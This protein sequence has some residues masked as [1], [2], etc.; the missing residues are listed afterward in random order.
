MLQFFYYIFIFDTLQ[1]S[2]TKSNHISVMASRW[3]QD[4]K[5]FLKWFWVRNNGNNLV[6]K[7]N[8]V[9]GQEDCIRREKYSPHIYGVVINQPVF[10]VQEKGKEWKLCKIGF[11]HCDTTQGRQGTKN[12][13]EQ[14]EREVKN[15]DDLKREAKTFFVLRIGAVD[16]TPY[17]ETE[18]RIRG[19]VG[20]RVCTKKAKA[21]KLPNPTEWVLTTQKHIGQI[22]KMKDEKARKVK[23][24]MEGDVID[25]FKDMDESN[26]PT[27]PKQFEV[28]WLKCECC[29]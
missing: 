16:T 10:P 15:N 21:L 18:G 11:T 23:T 2:Q 29:K 24:N 19:K 9:P 26:T 20:K 22:V 14:V 27:P 6:K 5:A 7:L 13:M 4:E 3:P 12:R 8:N 1:A 28:E 17:R 25:F